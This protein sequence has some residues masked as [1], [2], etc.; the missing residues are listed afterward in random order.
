MCLWSCHFLSSVCDGVSSKQECYAPQSRKGN[1]SVH[2]TAEQ[3]PGATKEPCDQ[4][5][6]Q[7]PYQTP[8][9]T[10]H[11]GENQ[12]DHIHSKNLLLIRMSI[13]YA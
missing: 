6:L 9:N 4:V 7:N 2:E 3:R 5:K 11:D 1:H 13:G 10:T 8:V 12:S